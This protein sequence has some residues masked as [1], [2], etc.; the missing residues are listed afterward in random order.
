MSSKPRPN[1]GVAALGASISAGLGVAVNFATDL[2]T[3]FLA[4]LAVTVLTVAAAAVA[5]TADLLSKKRSASSSESLEVFARAESGGRTYQTIHYHQPL[6]RAI[7]AI[8]AIVWLTA[9]GG[10]V[11]GATLKGDAVPG[12]ASAEGRAPLVAVRTLDHFCTNWVTTKS[13]S[14]IRSSLPIPSE[15]IGSGYWHDWAPLS[16]GVSA[17]PAGVEITIQGAKSTQVVLTDIHVRVLSRRQPMRGLDLTGRCGGT[18]TFRLLDVD[19]DRDPPATVPQEVPGA[20]MGDEPKWATTPIRF[21]YRVSSTDAETFVIV[22][23]TTLYDVDWVV[24]L[25]WS[26]AGVTGTMVVD[27]KGKPFRTTSTANSIY[28]P[29]TESTACSTG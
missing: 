23:S 22:A 17:S 8:S 6:L 18:G 3:S 27:D 5:V 26:S 13:P 14:D 25:S 1:W 2:K 20:L 19:L 24:D 9:A 11:A 10:L 7:T 21:P 15:L 16:D 12:E 28:C 29:L 4:W